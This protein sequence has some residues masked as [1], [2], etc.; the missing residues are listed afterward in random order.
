MIGYRKQ[1]ERDLKRW[2][3]EGIVG[4]EAEAAIRADVQSR[5]GGVALAP[6]LAIFGAVL[7]CFAAMTFVAANWQD[8]TKL[9]RLS[10]LFA[11]LWGAYAAAWAFQRKDMPHFSQAA[12][13][14]GLGLFGASIMLVAQMYHIEGD[15]PDAVLTWAGGSLLAGVLLRSR[16]ALALTIV[17]VSLW[18]WWE[19]A[20][21]DGRT[22]WAFLVGWLATAAPVV[23]LRWRSGYYLLALSL[24]TW[25]VGL[26][27]QLDWPDLKGIEPAN[28]LVAGL[29]LAAAAA[30]YVVPRYA[31]LEADVPRLLT[32]YGLV[33]AY[34]G[35]FAIQFVEKTPGWGIA[36][37][38]VLSLVLIVGVLI[39]AMRT[40][41]RAQSALAYLLF[42]A[43]LLGLY[44]K[45]LGT[46]LD[47]ALFFLIA[48]V[49]VFALAA[50]AWRLRT[51]GQLTKGAAP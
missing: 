36:L 45:T 23:W 13:L 37:F 50:L 18:S 29:G 25:V 5:R 40:G 16:P 35:L 31:K 24:S 11:G 26:G 7:L 12:I 15:P 44:F 43:E 48:G 19:V 17:L 4:A 41:D 49:I 38:A 1:L 42:S 3:A 21:T 22:H 51:S 30:G 39:H 14:T 28:V 34:A 8:M 9:A 32:V 20:E 46:L 33:V 27:Y 10:L 6:V 2:R 47:T